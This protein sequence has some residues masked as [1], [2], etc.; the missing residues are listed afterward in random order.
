[1]DDRV[2]LILP[3]QSRAQKQVDTSLVIN[4][5]WSFAAGWLFSP[6]TSFAQSSHV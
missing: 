2:Q 1:M 5:G 3:S 6:I 4:F